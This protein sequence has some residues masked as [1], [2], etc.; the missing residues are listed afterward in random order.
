M[1]APLS[2][3]AQTKPSPVPVPPLENGDRLTRDEFERRYEAMPHL[4]KAELIEGVVYVPS[5]TRWQAHG[6]PHFKL[7]GWLAVYETATPGLGGGDN[8]TVRLPL[9]N[10]PQPDA[11]LSV[12]P[13]HGGQMREDDDGYVITAP[14]LVA[15]IAASSVSYDLGPKL[16]LYQRIGVREYLV[17]RVLDRAIDWFV[18]RGQQFEP[19][20]P[21]A[22]GVLRSEVFPGLWLDTAAV[23]AGDWRKVHDVLRQGL[24]SAAHG[25]FVAQLRNAV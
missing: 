7:I 10:Q 1:T 8:T 21:D 15:E 4:K 18:L 20:T 23:L 5:P 19:L 11:F 22:A 2:T 25:A 6:G 16:R 24:D 17:W 12:L 13:A 3:A 14:D 9:D